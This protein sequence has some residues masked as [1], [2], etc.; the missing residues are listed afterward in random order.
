MFGFWKNKN[1]KEKL[2]E[3]I[4][5]EELSQD[6][7]SEDDIEEV[8]LEKEVKVNAPLKTLTKEEILNQMKSM[9]DLNVKPASGHIK[10]KNKYDLQLESLR[11]EIEEL[12][13]LQETKKGFKT[14]NLGQNILLGLMVLALG[15]AG[16]LGYE[17][18]EEYNNNFKDIN[19]QLKN[20]QNVIAEKNEENI[21]I[22]DLK[23]EDKIVKELTERITLV[24]KNN[25]E[26]STKINTLDTLTSQVNKID[27]KVTKVEENLVEYDERFKALSQVL[28]LVNINMQSISELKNQIGDTKSIESKDE[29]NKTE[30][31]KM[32][33]EFKNIND[34][35]TDLVSKQKNEILSL[36]E[37]IAKIEKDLNGKPVGEVT[38]MLTKEDQNK[39]T[40]LETRLLKNNDIINN[41]NK[42]FNNFL[43]EYN[44]S[45]VQELESSRIESK[46]VEN[47]DKEIVVDNPPFM[48]YKI[49][50]NKTFYIKN[51][52]NGKLLEQDINLG[53]VIIDRYEV[54]NIDKENQL[55][56][57]K[58]YETK[59]SI[60]LKEN[61]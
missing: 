51:R 19:K 33:L 9:V 11:K 5:E 44:A 39:I 3:I 53:D 16:Y 46:K 2:E 28:D 26:L 10:R 18:V 50:N 54:I 27:E 25:T 60:V 29:I 30:Y 59:K 32:L 37:K 34:L 38:N 45:K 49:I 36:N 41:L 43:E 22:K 7:S 56:I 40:M 24:E 12:I 42:S 17:K 58:D 31:D 61:K 23:I 57:F 55:V 20:M 13:V 48:I 21:N 4:I 14:S 6:N 1:K 52:L 47:Q 8:I 15:S 35:M